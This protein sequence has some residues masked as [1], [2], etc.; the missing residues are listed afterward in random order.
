M[1]IRPDRSMLL[2]IDLQERLLPAIDG[3]DAALANAI[4][5]T[6][7]ARRLAIPVGA[8][9]QYPK[10]LG[11]TVA[12]L[13]AVLAPAETVEKIHFSA[14][15][16]RRLEGLAG[17]ERP[18]VVITGTESHVCV[19]QTVLDLRA[20]GKEVFVVADA[21][22]SRRAEDR[23]MAIARMRDAGTHIVTREMVAFE[24]LEK[25]GTEVFR[26]ISREFLR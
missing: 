26:E 1:L 15:R 8:T 11:G 23:T 24:W 17:F 16:D 13:D 25:A 5:L 22:G 20:G 7:I 12:A 19:L 21:V 14:V 3:G 4:W 18:Q 10:G 6:R 9:V 2:H